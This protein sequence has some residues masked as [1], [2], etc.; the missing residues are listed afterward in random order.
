MKDMIRE[1]SPAEINKAIDQ[2][3]LE[4]LERYKDA[5]PGEIQT[6]LDVL[7]ESWDLECYVEMFGAGVTLAGIALASRYRR[8]WFVPAISSALV[9]AHAMPVWD[10]LTP[11]FRLFG[12]WSR[13]EIE[14]EKFALKILRGD[15]E[16]LETDR[17]AKSALAA[18][19]GSVGLKE[20]G[21]MRSEKRRTTRRSKADTSV[22]RSMG[23]T[24]EEPG[25]THTMPLGDVL[26]EDLKPS[27]LSTGRESDSNPT[28]H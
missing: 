18:A 19:Q 28:R 9:F 20:G 6:R 14:R 26:G 16:R 1:N 2:Q 24:P 10:P 15:F 3:T 23:M 21:P 13:Q 22:D 25:T 12:V 27:M 4:L 7:D 8:L 11:F 17:S 5:A